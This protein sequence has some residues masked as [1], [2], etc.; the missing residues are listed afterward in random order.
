MIPK[1]NLFGHKEAK[2]KT[3]ALQSKGRNQP[4]SN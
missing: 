2:E 1:D 3:E 4:T